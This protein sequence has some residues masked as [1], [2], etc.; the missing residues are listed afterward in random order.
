MLWKESFGV[1]GTLCKL[2]LIFY[3]WNLYYFDLMNL[4]FLVI[5]HRI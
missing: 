1:L 3:A 4:N 2:S 5:I